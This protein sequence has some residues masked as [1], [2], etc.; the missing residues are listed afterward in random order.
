MNPAISLLLSLLALQYLTSTQATK[1]SADHHNQNGRRFSYATPILI[2]IRTV[3][4]D[5]SVPLGRPSFV[6]HSTPRKSLCGETSMLQGYAADAKLGENIGD[7]IKCNVDRESRLRMTKPSP[8][9]A[10]DGSAVSSGNTLKRFRRRRSFLHQRQRFPSS[11]EA[12]D[13][14]I[15]TEKSIALENVGHDASQNSARDDVKMRQRRTK[16]DLVFRT[17]DGELREKKLMTRNAFA[18]L[19]PWSRHLFHIHGL[20]QKS[21]ARPRRRSGAVS[22]EWKKRVWED[23][24]MPAWG[25]RLA[26]DDDSDERKD[27]RTIE[28][29]AKP[30]ELVR[31]G[32]SSYDNS[33]N[34]QPEEP[35]KDNVGWKKRD[36]EDI[37]MHAW[38]KRATARDRSFVEPLENINDDIIAH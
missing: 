19:N 24:D 1:S 26:E 10:T 5:V 8:V 33:D 6:D 20:R 11:I 18:N 17:T 21:L 14:D 32:S 2:K 27:S 16:R 38:G 35:T 30:Q 3:S 37:D 12:T 31:L 13:S 7:I 28:S 22:P 9:I 4:S 36:W 15:Y 25:K 34:F 29:L 23:I